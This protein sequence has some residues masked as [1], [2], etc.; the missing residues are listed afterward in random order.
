M[1]IAMHVLQKTNGSTDWY[2]ECPEEVCRRKHSNSGNSGSP[3]WVSTQR[4]RHCPL[5]GGKAI[6][7]LSVARS[8]E[9]RVLRQGDGLVLNR[10]PATANGLENAT[11]LLASLT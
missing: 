7:H 8:E 11:A 10:F 6:N 3:G 9:Y 1:E 2:Q 4:D 5:C